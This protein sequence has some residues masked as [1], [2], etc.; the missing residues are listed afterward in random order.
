MKND[1]ILVAYHIE[2]KGVGVQVEWRGQPKDEK[3]C[4]GA[5]LTPVSEGG[6]LAPYF[7]VPL[8]FSTDQLPRVV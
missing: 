1:M 6:L 2:C 3:A 8:T 5:D 4:K 7:P